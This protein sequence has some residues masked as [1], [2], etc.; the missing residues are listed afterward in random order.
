MIFKAAF[1]I[2]TYIAR[3]IQNRPDLV[4]AGRDWAKNCQWG[5]TE[6]DPENSFID[7]YSPEA[8][9]KRINRAYDGGI[10]QFVK[11]NL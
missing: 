10:D 1:D 7:E 11:D 5:E 9:L 3:I 8:L 2:N 4:Q 6:E